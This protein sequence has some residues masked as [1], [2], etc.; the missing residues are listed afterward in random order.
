MMAQLVG[1]AVARASLSRATIDEMM[2]LFSEHYELACPENFRR[3]LA[4]KDQVVLLRDEASGDSGV[5]EDDQI[6]SAM[7]ET[8][9]AIHN[10]MN[11]VSTVSLRPQPSWIR[12]LQHELAE[13]Y[14]VGS[15]SR[16]RE[17]QRFVEVVRQRD[18]S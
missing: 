14:N 10:V 1:E 7:Y 12:R 3:D 9:T 16:G 13:R 15:R 11:G 18:Y 5:S 4:A 2:Q 6:A 17:P 8:E